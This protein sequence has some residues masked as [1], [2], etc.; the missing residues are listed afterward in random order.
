MDL[1]A[2]PTFGMIGGFDLK[3]MNQYFST[4]LIRANIAAQRGEA[5]LSTEAGR[6]QSKESQ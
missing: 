4:T 5:G 3:Y 2:T 6:T 1:S